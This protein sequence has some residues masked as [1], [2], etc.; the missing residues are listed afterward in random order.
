MGQAHEA[1]SVVVHDMACC[2]TSMSFSAALLLFFDAASR[3]ASTSASHASGCATDTCP[4]LP[5]ASISHLRK[6]LLMPE[7]GTTEGHGNSEQPQEHASW[8]MHACTMRIL[9]HGTP[10]HGDVL[11]CEQVDINSCTMRMHAHSTS[12]HGDVIP[13]EQVNIIFW[14]GMHG[15]VQAFQRLQR[16]HAECIWTAGLATSAAPSTECRAPAQVRPQAGE[17][18]MA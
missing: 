8:P 17:R 10:L 7:A 12:L 9:A 18:F 4:P 5:Y 15:R 6:P 11:P 14:Q 3:L 1:A 2:H 13:C 16:A